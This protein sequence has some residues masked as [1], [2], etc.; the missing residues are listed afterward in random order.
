MTSVCLR[1]GLKVLHYLNRGLGAC[2]WKC[3]PKWICEVE[4][5]KVILTA[6]GKRKKLVKTSGRQIVLQQDNQDSLFLQTGAGGMQKTHF[7]LKEWLLQ[8]PKSC[9]MSKMY[10]SFSFFSWLLLC[11]ALATCLHIQQCRMKCCAGAMSQ[12]SSRVSLV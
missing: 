8:Q 12:G 5:T 11:S 2:F 4:I 3:W 7:F 10:W 1:L 6:S 9:W